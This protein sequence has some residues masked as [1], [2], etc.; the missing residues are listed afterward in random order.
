M[1]R[2]HTPSQQTKHT[3]APSTSL[4]PAASVQTWLPEDAEGQHLPEPCLAPRHCSWIALGTHSTN[5]H[6]IFSA[7][8]RCA[9][10][11]LLLPGSVQSCLTPLLST[12]HLPPRPTPYQLLEDSEF[13]AGCSSLADVVQMILLQRHFIIPLSWHICLHPSSDSTETSTDCFCHV[14][15]SINHFTTSVY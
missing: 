14:W 4:S 13:Q 9:P 6:P 8:A 15:S 12:L 10:H 2:G 3:T 11:Q 5:C 7:S 1:Q